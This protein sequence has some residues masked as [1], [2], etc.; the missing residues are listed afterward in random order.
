MWRRS[1]TWRGTLTFSSTSECGLS[2]AVRQAALAARLSS[3]RRSPLRR[4]FSHLLTQ[5]FVLPRLGSHPPVLPRLGSHPPRQCNYYD[6]CNKY[7]PAKAGERP[8]P[9]PLPPECLQGGNRPAAGPPAAAHA[10]AT[11]A[12]LPSQP[13]AKTQTP[14]LSPAP[15]PASPCGMSS[16]THRPST[17]SA[18]ARRTLACAASSRWA[19]P[20]APGAAAARS[21]RNP[22]MLLPAWPCGESWC[23]QPCT[24][25]P[26]RLTAAPPPAASA[27]RRSS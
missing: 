2:P 7:A 18:P 19:R 5:S 9:R 20:P 27:H 10:T 12:V 21:R 4:P 15:Q 26:D 17:S 8:P 13:A 22:L 25:P 16:T 3:L 6:E 11:P 14:A 1:L 23:E 24:P